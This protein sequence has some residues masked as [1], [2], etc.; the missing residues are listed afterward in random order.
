MIEVDLKST[1]KELFAS[2]SE[3]EAKERYRVAVT[4]YFKAIAVACDQSE[5]GLA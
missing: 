5:G 2:G 1:I 4:L 3:E